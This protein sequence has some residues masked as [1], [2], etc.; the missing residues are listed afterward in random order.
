MNDAYKSPI[1]LTGLITINRTGSVASNGTCSIYEVKYLGVLP[2]A[3]GPAA[4]KGA[5]AKAAKTTTSASKATAT[6]KRTTATGEIA[7]N[8]GREKG[9]T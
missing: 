4:A 7:K 2:V 8:N 9:T 1:R 6:T 3:A 5:A